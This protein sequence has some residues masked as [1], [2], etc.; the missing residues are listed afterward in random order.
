M[1]EESIMDP[2]PSTI[3][4]TSEEIMRDRLLR[5]YSEQIYLLKNGGSNDVRAIANGA[6]ESIHQLFPE[7][8]EQNEYYWG[9]AHLSDLIYK[10]AQER[11]EKGGLPGFD[12]GF[13]TINN[14]FGGFTESEI[15]AFIARSGTGKTTMLTQLADTISRQ[16]TTVF[17]SPEAKAL[18]LGT[19]LISMLTNIQFMQIF[20]G[21]ISDRE[22]DLVRR[23]TEVMKKRPLFIY[24]MPAIHTREMGRIIDR[25][26]RSTGQRVGCIIIDYL[27]QM[28]GEETY[29]DISN[30][31]KAVEVLTRK[32]NVM[33]I[34]TSQANRASDDGTGLGAG[35]GSGKIEDLAAGVFNL[36]RPK[37]TKDNPYPDKNLRHLICSKNRPTGNT[38]TLDLRFVPQMGKYKEDGL[39]D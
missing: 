29:I 20:R 36:V 38:F 30:N 11:K 17:F 35:R 26:E 31:M 32:R 21:D 22:L 24:D 16:T 8:A 4:L 14:M 1:S 2:A 25:V 37:P 7:E 18:N 19:R 12:T 33:T 13:P 10:Y 5:F 39:S 15:Y 27:Q 9:P 34:L 23:A 28:D 6:I 3:E